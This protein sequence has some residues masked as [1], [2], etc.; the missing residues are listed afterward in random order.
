MKESPLRG[1]PGPLPSGGNIGAPY[2]AILS[3]LRLTIGLPIWLF[4]TSMVQNAV[5]SPQLNQ[6]SVD[7]EV[8]TSPS[9]SFVSPSPS[10]SSLGENSDTSNQ[11]AEKKKKWKEKKKNPIQ[12]GGNQATIASN[13]S[14]N[15]NFPSKLPKAKFPCIICAGDHFH[16]DCP[17]FPRILKEWSP[18][19]HHL[20]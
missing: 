5:I 2:M 4:S 9:S 7:P 3:L 1:N 18:C 13:A 14:S 16:R 12:Q 10:S 8:D 15:E 17:C 19:S 6:P 20:E 11:V